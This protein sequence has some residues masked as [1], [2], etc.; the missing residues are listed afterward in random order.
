MDE[1]GEFIRFQK[2]DAGKLRRGEFRLAR[3]EAEGLRGLDELAQRVRRGKAL[4]VQSRIE[5]HAADLAEA[6]DQPE[7]IALRQRLRAHVSSPSPD[8][9][10]T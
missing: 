2:A 6:A 4:Q 8:A 7:K 9:Q 3:L 5:R 1:M 10:A